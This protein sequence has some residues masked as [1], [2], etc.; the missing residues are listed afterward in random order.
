MMD[1]PITIRIAEYQSALAETMNGAGL[2]AWLQLYVL[3]PMVSQ[4]EALAASETE[5]E[6]KK[7]EESKANGD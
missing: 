1:K 6:R 3:R 7:W 2:P 5:E 4:M